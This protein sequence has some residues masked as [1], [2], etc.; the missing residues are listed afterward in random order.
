MLCMHD[1]HL[2]WGELSVAGVPIVPVLTPS[3]LVATLRA[4]PAH[5]DKVGVMLRAE[6]LATSSTPA[7]CGSYSGAIIRS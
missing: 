5:L 3:R 1:T 2:L 6:H 4:L 7:A